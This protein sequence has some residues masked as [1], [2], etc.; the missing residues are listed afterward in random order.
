MKQKEFVLTALVLLMAVGISLYFGLAEAADVLAFQSPLPTATPETPTPTPDTPTPLPDT[1][2]PTPEP[3]IPDTITLIVAG[4][5]SV[6]TGE[7]VE[8][9][10]VAQ[11]VTGDGLYGVQLELN[12]DPALISA[13]NLQVNPD[14]DF[15]VRN[16]A[17]NGLGK[18]SLAASRQGDVPGLTGDIILLTFEATAAASPGT[19][20]FDFEN[21]K[22][23]D[24]QATPLEFA[25]ESY[26]LTIVES[27]TPVPDTP[28]PVP[29]T[30]TPVPDTPTPVPDTPTPI[31]DTP[32][33][34]PDTPTPV[35]DTPTPVPDTPTPVPDTPTPVPD[36]PTPVPDTPT[37]IPDTP[38]PTPEPVTVAIFGQVILSG[39]VGNNW[40]GATL[41]INEGV[42]EA[43]TDTNGNFSMVN[44][45]GASLTTITADAPGYLPAVCSGPSVAPPETELNMVALL[46]GDLNDDKLVD[47][48][49][50]TA[51]GLSFGETDP[52]LVA[53]INK[54]GI[55]DIF[56]IVLATINYG[57][58]SQNWNCTGGS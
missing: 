4:P 22:M 36:T 49:D 52:G 48:T 40:S 5:A 44:V 51:V 11:A 3:P 47:I 41:S 26:T 17:D 34:V 9:N 8:L 56:D 38:T 39:R 27:S 19:V 57:K 32:T 18:I 21:V 37:P 58:S 30:P 33:P 1:P 10:I 53:D 50:A 15:I 2:T 16:E 43:V 28:T 12:Y 20:N 6:G 42:P 35:P 55:V 7:T 31:P 46:T 14:L 29:D 23:S 13:G 54:D 45:D 25:A 24:K